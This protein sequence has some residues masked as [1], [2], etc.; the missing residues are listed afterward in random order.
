[1]VILII[2]KV[3][4]IG[5]NNACLHNFNNDAKLRRFAVLRCIITLNTPL[6]RRSQ[7]TRRAQPAQTAPVGFIHKRFDWH[8]RLN[9]LRLVHS[10][11]GSTGTNGSSWVHSQSPPRAQ[12][13]Q[14]AP[15]GSEGRMLIGYWPNAFLK[16][17]VF[18]AL[19]STF[20]GV[21]EAIS[22]EV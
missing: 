13:A 2:P 21:I 16:R 20:S 1:M 6:Q 18:A 3:I 5:I 11:V 15:V 14:T 17:D 8:N 10:L 19:D 7:S 9:W 12:P 22:A 4:F